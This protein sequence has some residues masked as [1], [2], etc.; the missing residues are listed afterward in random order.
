MLLQGSL[1]NNW[2]A[3]HPSCDLAFVDVSGRVAGALINLCQQPDAQPMSNFTVIRSTRQ[4]IAKLIG[5]SREMVG[6]VLKQF[7]EANHISLRGKK[8]IIYKGGLE[9]I[10]DS[11]P[12]FS[13]LTKK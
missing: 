11:K 5:C 4:E 1:Q 10:R 2:Q 9:S 3:H 12:N 6:R 7:D 13:G 8:I